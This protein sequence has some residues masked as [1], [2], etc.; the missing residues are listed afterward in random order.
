MCKTGSL[1]RYL[2][3]GSDG[4]NADATLGLRQC[5]AQLTG[6]SFLGLPKISENE[7]RL[8]GQA[9]TELRRINLIGQVWNTS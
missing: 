7:E 3:G 5:Q 8:I 4:N 9:I 1:L 2:V 6:D